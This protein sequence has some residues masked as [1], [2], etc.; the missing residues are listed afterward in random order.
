MVDDIDRLKS[1]SSSGNRAREILE[2]MR[3]EQGM[4]NMERYREGALA[5]YAGKVLLDNVLYQ[6]DGQNKMLETHDYPPGSTE[7]DIK[8]SLEMWRFIQKHFDDPKLAWLRAP[9]QKVNTNPQH[10]DA[11]W[12]DPTQPMRFEDGIPVN[13]FAGLL[14]PELRKLGRKDDYAGSILKPEIHFPHLQGMTSQQQTEAMFR[15]VTQR[16]ILSFLDWNLAIGDAQS[17]V[18]SIESELKDSSKHPFSFA[19][20]REDHEHSLKTWQFVRDHLED[21]QLAWLKKVDEYRQEKTNR[22]K[23]EAKEVLPTEVSPDLKPKA[24]SISVISTVSET[25]K[26]PKRTLEQQVYEDKIVP[27]W[28]LKNLYG[29]PPESVAETF[30]R[31]AQ[32]KPD[33]Y[34]S[35]YEAIRY[36]LDHLDQYP[37]AKKEIEDRKKR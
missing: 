24:A 26:P 8:D 22:R 33:E 9:E 14:I 13:L 35:S 20:T 5:P 18:A 16:D 31:W 4:A 7:L 6:I 21:P 11:S 3:Y 30:K 15:Y 25:T 17:E 12:V 32:E 23:S 29:T 36:I 34:R 37:A 2:K 27:D 28:I 10:R 19:G 1:P